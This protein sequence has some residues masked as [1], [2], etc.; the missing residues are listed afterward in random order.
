MTKKTRRMRFGTWCK[1]DPN[2][3]TKIVYT[4]HMKESDGSEHTMYF[5]SE[6]KA[7]YSLL[8]RLRAA[9]I[10]KLERVTNELSDHWFAELYED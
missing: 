1:K 8:N 6:D 4:F 9:W 7:S 10:M 2:D 5:T 3:E